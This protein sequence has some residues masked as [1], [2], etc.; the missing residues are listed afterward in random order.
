MAMIPFV[1][2]VGQAGELRDELMAAVGDVVDEAR[3]ILG[4][5]VESFERAFAD[6]CGARHCVGTS[7][8][9]EALHLVLRALDVGPGDEVITA[10]NTFIATALAIAYAGATPVLVD[11]HPDDYT[12]D[13]EYLERAI[14][15]RT[16]AILPVHLYGQ[17]ADMPAILEIARRH[18]LPVVQDACQAHGALIAGQPLG[19]FGDAACYSFYPSKNLGGLGDG[20]AVVTGSDQLAGRLRR[21]RNYGQES[22]NV[23]TTLGFN[24]RLDTLQAAVLEVKLRHLDRWNARRRVAAGKYGQLL[25]E[26]DLVLPSERPGTRHVYHL[27]VVRHANRDELLRHLQQFGMQCGIHYP[28]PLHLTG[29]FQSVRTVP[30]GA[31]VSRRLSREILSLPMFPEIRDDQLQQ[32]AD[33]VMAF[34]S[35]IATV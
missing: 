19:A 7:S 35:E 1:D 8:G 3:Y 18:E 24:C 29:P 11:C 25:R 34:S 32:V 13:V 31:P 17:P 14:T 10:A 5:Q 33:A 20:G 9:T 22:K 15:R 27:Y 2:L 21:L 28:D 26:A 23:Y 4:P 16:K 12:I 6:Y 30:D